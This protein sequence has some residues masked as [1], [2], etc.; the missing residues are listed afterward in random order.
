MDH[1]CQGGLMDYAFDFI[2]K[3]GGLDSENDYPYTAT[4]QMCKLRKE[5]RDIASIT[6]F[7]DVPQGD[8]AA[9]LKA[10]SQQPVSVAIE[11]D[12]F[13]FQFYSTGVINTP[14]CGTNL[15]HGVLVVG[16]GVET[17]TTDGIPVDYWIVKNSW[18]PGGGE[19]GYLRIA[20]H[21]SLGVI[22]PGTCGIA[23]SAS[24]PVI[25]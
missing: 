7:E 9:M 8:E 12:Q 13:A 11:A 24:Y 1:G 3:N 15:D 19:D 5:K 4:Q 2:V 18:G 14:L 17:N 25:D 6:G 21:S 22:G 16:Y 23:L 20:R 10:V